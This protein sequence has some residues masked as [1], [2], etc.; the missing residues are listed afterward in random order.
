MGSS[1]HKYRDYEAYQIQNKVLDERI[2][3]ALFA[4]EGTFEF[5]FTD[6]YKLSSELE[7]WGLSIKISVWSIETWFVF[8][9]D[10]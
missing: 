10:L 1:N 5:W 7:Y 9:E 8:P 4:E 2:P 6:W 3:C